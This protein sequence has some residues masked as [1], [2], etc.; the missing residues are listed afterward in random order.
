MSWAETSFWLACFQV[1]TK[2]ICVL[3]QRLSLSQ[4]LVCGEGSAH[5]MGNSGPCGIRG[6]THWAWVTQE[7][8]LYNQ[9]KYLE[10]CSWDKVITSHAG[11]QK[12]I[13]SSGEEGILS[14]SL[15]VTRLT[16][17]FLKFTFNGKV[18]AARITHR[19]HMQSGGFVPCLSTEAGSSR[20]R[21]CLYTKRT[22]RTALTDVTVM[23]KIFH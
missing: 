2:T 10:L 16:S 17:W 1:T 7:R 8:L 18:I 6:V 19:R 12:P 22:T 3:R 15:V 23:A 21:T 20:S 5:S 9:W 13:P 14:G 4:V 11:G